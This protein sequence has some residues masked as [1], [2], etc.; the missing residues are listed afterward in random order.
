MKLISIWNPKGGQGKS[1]VAINLAASAIEIGLKTIIIDRDMQGTSMMFYNEGNL[2]FEVLPSI[3]KEAPNVDL[4]I[5]DHPANDYDVPESQRIIMPFLPVRSQYAAY[6][7][8]FL[9][10]QKENKNIVSVVTKGDSRVKIEKETMNQVRREGAFQIKRSGVFGL[11]DSE[12]RTIFDKKYNN[13]Y[14][15][16][17]TRSEVS[18]ILTAIIREN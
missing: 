13:Q 2:P 8:N 3:P 12:F 14:R 6:A 5:F 17:R 1:L 15:I 4:V 11:A 9:K 7:L 18:A 16:E 10:A